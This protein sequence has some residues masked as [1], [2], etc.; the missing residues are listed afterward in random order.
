MQAI[1]LI[2]EKLRE[3]GQLEAA[4]SAGLEIIAKEL[5]CEEGSVW[6]LNRDDNRLYAVVNVGQTDITGFSIEQGQGI[7]GSTV[8]SGTSVI[9]ADTSK[10]ERFSSGVDDETGFH[11][12]SIIC[13]PLKKGDEN[14]DSV[15]K[16]YFESVKSGARRKI[17]FQK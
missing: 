4:L 11:T 2:T 1:W 6:V 13:V 17:E 3:A 5:A 8:Q 7:A 16:E 14:K 10:D 12:R 9:V 15:A